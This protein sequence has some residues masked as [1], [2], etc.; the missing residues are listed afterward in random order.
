MTA[1]MLNDLLRIDDLSNIKIKFTIH[2]G[3]EDPMD[4]Y[5]KNPDVVNNQWLFWRTKQRY[6]NVGE[7]AICFLRIGYDQWLLT[8]IKKVTKELGKIKSINYEGTELE[9]YSKYFGRVVIKFHKTFQSGV[10][11]SEPLIND[12]EVLQI[13][14]TAFDGID[15]PGYDKVHLSYQQLETIIQRQ[16]VDWIKALENQKAIYLIR[17]DK[18]GKHYVGSATGDNGM[19]LQRWSSYVSDGHGGNVELLNIVNDT[20][21]GMDYIKKHFNFSILENYNSRVDRNFILQREN[22]WKNILGTRKPNGYNAN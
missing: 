18:N 6:F 2:N 9:E 17:D 16:K 11:W 7:T 15:F 5:T 20:G 21:K 4:V 14:P 19:L 1:I 8:T 22:W 12:L 10:R 3:I 13:L